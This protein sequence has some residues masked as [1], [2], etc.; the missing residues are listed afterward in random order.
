MPFSASGE[1]FKPVSF[2]NI[3]GVLDSYVGNGIIDYDGTERKSIYAIAMLTS[4]L[5]TAIPLIV[6]SG[7]K[8][9]V[10][11]PNRPLVIPT[12]VVINRVSIRMPEYGNRLEGASSYGLLPQ[13]CNIVGTTG[14]RIKV[15]PTTVT[16]HTTVAPSLQCAD[17]RYT[18]DSFS[19]AWRPSG[20]ADITPPSWITTT[21]APITPQITVSNTGNTAAGTGVALSQPGAIAFIV[22]WIDLESD[23][24]PRRLR[25]INLPIPPG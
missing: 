14:D 3:N 5:Q 20:V 13:E 12:G 25:E 10:T 15:S 21:A 7:K 18:P 16:T 4:T 1:P 24:T 22:V 9:L 2:G 17:S 19:T 11:S 6:P 23:A 8:D